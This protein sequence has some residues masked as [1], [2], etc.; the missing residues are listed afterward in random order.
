MKKLFIIALLSVS[1]TASAAQV[2]YGSPVASDSNLTWDISNQVLGIT[3]TNT[4]TPITITGYG[5]GGYLTR[6]YLRG[7][8]ASTG[9][10]MFILSD[11]GTGNESVAGFGGSYSHSGRGAEINFYDTDLAGDKRTSVIS[12]NYDGSGGYGLKFETK[13]SGGSFNTGLFQDGSGNVGV[14]TVTPGYRLDV[15]GYANISGRLTVS[16]LGNFTN[17][18]YFAEF[19]NGFG[20]YGTDGTN[21]T[22][23]GTGT[24]AIDASGDL[25]ETGNI[26]VD[27]GSII[28]KDTVTG[29]C[30]PIHLTNGSL[31]VGSSVTC[32]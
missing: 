15:N 4:H 10:T 12:G 22:K 25:R 19:A 31:V 7:I 18:I 29:L 13:D 27:T 21:W 26:Y 5:D 32:H 30:K 23:L 8:S 1:L 2:N 3:G 20:V 14:G 9:K 11:D 24:Y 17:G 6:G 16:D 28:L